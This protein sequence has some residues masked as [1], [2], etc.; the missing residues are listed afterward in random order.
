MHTR[1]LRA[2]TALA[3][4]GA[5][6]SLSVGC[7]KR[8]PAELSPPGAP[9]E[10]IS[11]QGDSL[12][13]PS[14]DSITRARMEQ[15]LAEARLEAAERP[16]HPDALIWVGRRAAYLGR[17]GEAIDVFTSGIRRF[18]S[19]ARFYRHRGHRYITV[20]RFDDAIADLTRATELMRGRPDE[21]EPDGQ[22]NPRNIPIGSLHSNVWYHLALAH[23]LKGDWNNAVDAARMGLSVSSN[24]DRLVSQSHWL[25]MALR[26]AGRNAEAAE[27]LMPIRDDF[28]IVENESYYRLV[29]LYKGTLPLSS[30]DSVTA[31]GVRSSSDAS[32]GYGLAN[33]HLYGGDTTSAIRAFE[34]LIAAGQWTSFGHIAAEA[35]LARLRRRK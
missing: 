24:P 2:G 31:G 14:L 19:D 12:R 7:V 15:Q 11:L 6:A 22:P 20:R 18:P 32:L 4:W 33:W 21:V 30:F 26:R 13:R 23:Y 25:Y 3:C 5:A 34:K 10:A 16:N 28:D 8:S 27:A 17:F 1:T 35:D 29:R 9:V